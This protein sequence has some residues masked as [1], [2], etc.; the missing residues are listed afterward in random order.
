M[1]ND[2]ASPDHVERRML[3]FFA[4]RNRSARPIP[5]SYTSKQLT[6]TFSRRHLLAASQNTETDS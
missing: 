2:F 1:P 5:W 3:T 4:E 6:A